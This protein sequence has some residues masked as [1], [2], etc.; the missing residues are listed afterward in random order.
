[1]GI[2]SDLFH[3]NKLQTLT[4]P[5]MVTIM[6]VIASNEI[7]AGRLPQI[8]TQTLMLN[9]DELCC[10]ID[11]ACLIT[12]NMNTRYEGTRNGISIRLMKGLSYHTGRNNCNRI[13]EKTSEYTPGFLYITNNRIIFVAKENSFEKLI[14]KI[15]ALTSYTNAI[16]IQFNDKTYN[17][18]L[19][20]PDLAITVMH[21]IK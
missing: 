9:K 5:I 4:P 13:R 15:V 1:M 12:E 20:Q 11:K 14:K 10:F 17:L 7:K 2:L 3:F 21:L 19:P 18:L 16:G 6:P 8:N